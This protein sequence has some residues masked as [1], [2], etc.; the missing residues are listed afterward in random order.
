MY[1]RLQDL[2]DFLVDALKISFN[3]IQSVVCFFVC[4]ATRFLNFISLSTITSSSFSLFVSLNIF[5]YSLY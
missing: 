2:K 3:H 5:P 4:A 1:C